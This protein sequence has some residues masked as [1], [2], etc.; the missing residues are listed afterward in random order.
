MGRLSSTVSSV[1]VA[2]IAAGL[3]LLLGDPRLA[4]AAGGPFA[5]NGWQLHDYNVPKLEEAIRRAPSYGVNFVIFSHELFRSVEGFLAS[6]DDA[7]PRRPSDEV[8][9]LRRGENFR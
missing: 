5:M 7:D 3:L 4:G 2:A 1:R 6:D 9:A 8:K